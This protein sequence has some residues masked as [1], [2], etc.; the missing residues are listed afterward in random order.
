[1]AF[2]GTEDWR[3]TTSGWLN[4]NQEKTQAVTAEGLSPG[5]QHITQQTKSSLNSKT[6]SAIQFIS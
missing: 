1:M 6:T 2:A 5:Q 3:R 4:V